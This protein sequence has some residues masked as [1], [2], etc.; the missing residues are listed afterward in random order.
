[1]TKLRDDGFLETSDPVVKACFLEKG[2]YIQDNGPFTLKDVNAEVYPILIPA[3]TV[4]EVCGFQ[5]AGNGMHFFEGQ[6]ETLN[7]LLVWFGKP[8]PELY[9]WLRKHGGGE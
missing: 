1:M 3:R 9:L 7:T 4:A 8:R 6:D 2:V 5:V